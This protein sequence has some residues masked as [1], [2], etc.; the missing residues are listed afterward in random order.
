M[1]RWWSLLLLRVSILPP[2]PLDYVV[3]IRWLD[4]ETLTTVYTKAEVSVSV[5]ILVV[6]LIRGAQAQ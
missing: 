4:L 3:F 1:I 6:S 5:A 2:L